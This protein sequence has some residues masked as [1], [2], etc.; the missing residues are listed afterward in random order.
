M[1]MVK[2]NPTVNALHIYGKNRANK[3]KYSGNAS[4]KSMHPDPQTPV[5]E[6][7]WL[8]NRDTMIKTSLIYDIP[9]ASVI[10]H[11]DNVED[12]PTT[13]TINAPPGITVFAP[14]VGK[15]QRMLVVSEL[16]QLFYM[17]KQNPSIVGYCLAPFQDMYI[18]FYPQNNKMPGFTVKQAIEAINSKQVPSTLDL[19]H[20]F[21]T[22]IQKTLQ[23]SPETFDACASIGIIKYESGAGFF[24]HIDNVVRLQGSIGPVFTMSLGGVAKH[25]DMLPVVAARTN[26]KNIPLRITVP[27]GGVILMDGISRLE[28]SHGVPE[29]DPT[30]RYTLMIKF[31]QLP[32]DNCRKV[33][34]SKVLGMPIYERIIFSSNSCNNQRCR[35]HD[36]HEKKTNNNDEANIIE[37]LLMAIPSL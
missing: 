36:S 32:N 12:S 34:Y 4:T 27:D 2:L 13:S 23:I 5:A 9:T 3:W 26:R 31:K 8:V 7:I 20:K 30:E 10:H 35:R 24:T 25:L 6:R 17:E 29:H 22:S 11:K 19:I 33:A 18:M 37:K 21:C 15:K 14:I 1:F 28:W 16:K